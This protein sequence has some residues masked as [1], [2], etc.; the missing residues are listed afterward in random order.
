MIVNYN[1][2]DILRDELRS[3]DILSPCYKC[4]EKQFEDVKSTFHKGF[5]EILE[6]RAKEIEE[7][8]W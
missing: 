8:L 7:N 5:T 3:T 1:L 2:A 4:T 6:E